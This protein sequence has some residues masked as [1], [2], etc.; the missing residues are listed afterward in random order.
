MVN[1][2]GR[3]ELKMPME[4]RAYCVYAFIFPS[5]THLHKFTISLYLYFFFL[6]LPLSFSSF[7]RTHTHS[8][9]LSRYVTPFVVVAADHEERVRVSAC[10]SVSESACERAWSS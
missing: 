1:Y 9:T 3:P 6:S 8:H 2:C 10:V 7:S 5:H 4:I